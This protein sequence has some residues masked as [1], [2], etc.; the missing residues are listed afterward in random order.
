MFETF[1][2]VEKGISHILLSE[3]SYSSLCV[4]TIFNQS[5]LSLGSV[6]KSPSS[7]NLSCYHL[8]RNGVPLLS[9]SDKETWE[10]AFYCLQLI[11]NEEWSTCWGTGCSATRNQQKYLRTL[12]F[13]PGPLALLF[14][15][16]GEVSDDCQSLGG[17]MTLL[18][19]L[20]TM[21]AS[22]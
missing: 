10:M 17:W 18:C 21:D 19:H 20:F 16:P 11:C 9:N 13:L 3:K 2:T 14:S 5:R 6:Y 4:E 7:G 15:T 12:V 1:P 22:E 8:S